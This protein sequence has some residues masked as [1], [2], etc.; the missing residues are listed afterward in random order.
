MMIECAN[1]TLTC[2]TVTTSPFTVTLPSKMISSHF[3]LEATAY[4]KG[5]RH[6]PA[7]HL[8][9]VSMSVWLRDQAALFLTNESCSKRLLG[10]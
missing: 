5:D 6:L 3:R 8:M 10:E 7:E 4:K 1:S 2:G 9:S